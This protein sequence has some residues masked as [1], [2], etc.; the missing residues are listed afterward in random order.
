MVASVRYMTMNRVTHAAVR[1]DLARL[2]AA[3]TAAPDGARAAEARESVARKT[4]GHSNRREI[5]PIWRA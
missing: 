2:E 4:L 1:R 5:A 3:L